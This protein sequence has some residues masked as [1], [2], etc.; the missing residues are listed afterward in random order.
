MFIGRKLRLINNE[1]VTINNVGNEK[2][3]NKNWN[4]MREDF[5]ASVDMNTKKLFPLNF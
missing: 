5:S 2:L 3:E 1:Q 4:Q